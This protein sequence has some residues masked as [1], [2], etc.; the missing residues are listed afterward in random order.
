M[1]EKSKIGAK[2]PTIQEKFYKSFGAMTVTMRY[3]PQIEQLKLQRLDIWMYGRGAE[4]LQS[5]VIL[6][7]GFYFSDM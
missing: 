3:L 4:R 5:R 7:N 1:V 2:M 6:E